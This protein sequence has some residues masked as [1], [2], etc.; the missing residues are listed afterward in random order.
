[1]NPGYSPLPVVGL[2]VFAH[3]LVAADDAGPRAIQMKRITLDTLTD[4]TRGSM[5]WSHG[6]FLFQ[7]VSAGG[8]PP[9][10]YT[11][12][13]DGV[14]LSETTPAVPDSEYVSVS[15][16]DRWADNS[17]VFIGQAWS[18]YGQRTSLIG[19]LSAD[20]ATEKIIRT[21]PYHPYMLSIAPDG[22]FWTVGLEMVDRD[23]SAPGLDP[24]AGVLRHFDRSGKVIGTS[25][26]QSQ[27]VKRYTTG[28]LDYGYLSAGEDRI[29]WYAPRSG[30]GGQYIEMALGSMTPRVYPGLPEL[31]EPGLVVCFRLTES[32]NAF[33]SVYDNKSEHSTTYMLD[34][35]ARKWAPLKGPM[36][37][38]RPGPYLIGV[39]GEQLV[40]RD[41]QSNAMFFTLSQ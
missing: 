15:S 12:G 2:L 28:R 29:G 27:F 11:L 38:L 41:W 8:R 33:L 30:A 25:G 32:G 21:A 7:T 3:L 9:T 23:I 16:C 10:F 1:M 13:R 26:P 36:V 14:L 5:K 19:L 39:D 40:F 4:Q 24:N 17:I 6:A 31:P 18:A 34:R 37:G 20:G 22:T 35:E